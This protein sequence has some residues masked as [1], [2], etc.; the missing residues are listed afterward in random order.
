MGQVI[1]IK[2]AELSQFIDE[3]VEEYKAYKK[4]QDELDSTIKKYENHPEVKDL[5]KALYDN[6]SELNAKVEHEKMYLENT[7]REVMMSKETFREC[8]AAGSRSADLIEQIKTKIRDI[9][10]KEGSN[11][12]KCFDFS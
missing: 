4:E 3:Q 10:K 9:E 7:G 6:D 8:M 11:I 1:N 5:I 2:D 12:V